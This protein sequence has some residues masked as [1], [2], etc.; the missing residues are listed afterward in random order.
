MTQQEE[1]R[2]PIII[3]TGFLGSGKTTL[4]KEL[5]QSNGG[6]KKIAVIMNEIGEVSI[7]AKILSGFSVEMFEL[8]DGCIC[9]SVNENFIEVLD[10]IAHKLSPDLIVIETTGVA[11]P[12]SLLYSILNPR[13][14]VDSVITVVDTKNFLRLSKEVDVAEEQIEAANILLLTK[15]NEAS[16]ELVENTRVLIHQLNPKAH[17]YL[18][19]E[20]PISILFGTESPISIE[21]EL[22]KTQIGFKENVHIHDSKEE[23]FENSHNHSHHHFELEGIENFTLHLPISF[24]LEKLQLFVESLPS[25]VWRV[26]GIISLWLEGKDSTVILNSAFGRYAIEDA[27]REGKSIPN[28]LVFIGKHIHSQKEL[29]TA[30][31]LNCRSTKDYSTSSLLARD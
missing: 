29:L 12:I 21:T 11:N 14:W 2:I 28:Q 8:N 27:P 1:K 20:V 19:E 16:E 18:K 10:E 3:V 22:P 4:L 25:N 5:L 23:H 24:D 26:K 17:I 31:L 9:C 6:T 7:D 30:S 15:N 13:F